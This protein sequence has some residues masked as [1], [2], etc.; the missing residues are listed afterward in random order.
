MKKS[1]LIR[2]SLKSLLHR[3]DL[4]IVRRNS[5]I[6]DW[7][8][9]QVVYDVGANV[10][11]YGG[12]IR[13]N[14]YKGR[15]YSFEPMPEEHRI[16]LKRTADDELWKVVDPCALGGSKGRA[17][18]HV[19]L[20]SFSSS[21]IEISETHV[22]SAPTSHSKSTISVEVKTLDSF[23]YDVEH[24]GL[25]SWLKI[26]V[27]G[28]EL[29]VLKGSL[30]TLRNVIG[31]QIELSTVELYAGQPLFNEIVAFLLSLNFELWDIEKGFTDK[32]TGRLLQF[33]AV[34]IRKHHLFG[35]SKE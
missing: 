34:F 24:I 14:G 10:G 18:L 2:E 21:I 15:I 4:K 32:E 17:D 31:I 5:E 30:R 9:I 1:F 6:I 25:A 35:R 11:Q 28:Y 33:D 22:K 3:F 8:T 29:E 7:S 12:R 27:Q 26:D 20:N 19:S 23:G 16:L 13:S